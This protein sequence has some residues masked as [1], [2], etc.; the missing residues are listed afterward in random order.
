MVCSKVGR[1][2]ST[3]VLGWVLA[4]GCSSQEQPDQLPPT[5]VSGNSGAG[6]AGGGGTIASDGG[7]AVA[8]AGSATND[9]SI[10]DPVLVR[11]LSQRDDAAAVSACSFA[12]PIPSNGYDEIRVFE[13]ES[14]TL[15]IPASASDGWTYLDASTIGLT[16]GYCDDALAGKIVFLY[17]IFTCPSH[18][19]P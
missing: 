2:G 9:A 6:G 10:C 11:L 14:L 7:V 8:D 18:P 19:T 3:L 1:V 16:G 12:L 4:T 17:V 5:N 15:Q 13:D